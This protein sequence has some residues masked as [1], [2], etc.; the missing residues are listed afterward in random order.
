MGTG[1]ARAVATPASPFVANA[2]AA[3]Q[4]ARP[5]RPPPPTIYSPPLARGFAGWAGL[6]RAGRQTRERVRGRRDAFGDQ[7]C[8]VTLPVGS[9]EADRAHASI[10]YHTWVGRR[11]HRRCD[12]LAMSLTP[13]RVASRHEQAQVAVVVEV[14]AAEVRPPSF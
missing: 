14:V 1:C 7:T 4:H 12:K 2:T 5:V 6:P 13:W 11:V 3:R 9:D 10:A 8:A